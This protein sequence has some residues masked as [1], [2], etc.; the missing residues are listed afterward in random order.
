MPDDASFEC[1][2]Y[3]KITCL[4]GSASVT[5]AANVLLSIADLKMGDF[6]IH[7]NTNRTKHSRIE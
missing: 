6:I 5:V 4:H 1:I 7:Q 3:I 2:S